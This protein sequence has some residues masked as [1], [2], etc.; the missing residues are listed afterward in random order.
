MNEILMKV[1][2]SMKMDEENK[3]LIAMKLTKDSQIYDFLKWLQKEVP[4]EK[5]SN[6]QDEIVGKAVEL[7]KIV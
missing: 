7:S 6:M 4:E 3:V 2:A 1:L 5:V